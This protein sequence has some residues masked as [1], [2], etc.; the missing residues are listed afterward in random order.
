MWQRKI[1]LVEVVNHKDLF[2]LV[3]AVKLKIT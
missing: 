2:A 1:N 3:I